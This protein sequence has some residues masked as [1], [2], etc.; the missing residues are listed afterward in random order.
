MNTFVISAMLLF[1]VAGLCRADAPVMLNTLDAGFNARAKVLGPMLTAFGSDADSFISNPAG[2]AYAPCPELG[3]TYNKLLMDTR[4][5]NT[6]FLYPL[7]RSGLGLSITQFD[8]GMF[9][10]IEA[11]QVTDNVLAKKDESVS[12]S[13]GHEI[14]QN[15]SL[16]VTGKYVRSSL[17]ETYSSQAFAADLGLLWQL[18]GNGIS[19]GAALYN[20]GTPMKYL[21]TDESLP[22]CAE[23]GAGISL[24]DTYRSRC[25]AGGGVKW[26]SGNNDTLCGSLAAEYVYNGLLSLRAGYSPGRSHLNPLML[27]VG[28][29]LWQNRLDCAWTNAGI[30]D[31]YRMSFT[32]SFGRSGLL[33]RGMGFMKKN[34]YKRA[35]DTFEKIP[36]AHPVYEEAQSALHYCESE[37]ASQQLAALPASLSVVSGKYPASI[38]L[39]RHIPTSIY[40]ILPGLNCM[41]CLVSIK[42][43][44][45]ETTEFLVKY[46][47]DFQKEECILRLELNP[48]DEK[49]AAFYPPVPTFFGA[50]IA[51][52]DVHAVHISIYAAGSSGKISKIIDDFSEPVIFHPN[53]QFF[54]WIKNAAGEKIQLIDTLAAWVVPNDP[55]LAGV[56]SKASDRGDAASPKIK[57]VGGQDTRIFLQAAEQIDNDYLKQIEM[58]YTTLIKDYHVNYLNQPILDIRGG[59][60]ASQ[61][62]KY[63]GQTLVN[64]GNCIELSVLFASILESIGINPIIVLLPRDGHCVV[65]WEIPGHDR[66]MYRLLETNHFGKDFEAVLR[67]PV[68]WI[69][70]YGLEEQ[71]NKGIV[72]DDK[73]IYQDGNIMILDV[74]SVR[75]RIYPSPY[76]VK[77][78]KKPGKVQ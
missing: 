42:N 21:D 40:N 74:A 26:E 8:G 9:D 54:L 18:P 56:V 71:F 19:L 39:M 48:G 33:G 32:F 66:K 49:T 17:I 52:Q 2:L 29:F 41:P 1:S 6:C 7:K 20:L 13:F 14:F 24:C 31:V 16:G 47:F 45:A 70:K 55:A 30:E 44:T 75:K 77:Q 65:G 28:F 72:F 15:L 23:F 11:G 3:I 12:I 64:K 4:I 73:G 43:N 22:L 10:I 36:A 25:V 58:I 5:A 51:T 35:A 76:A 59:I 27:G 63:P 61:R 68:V 67:E 46:R 78:A 38:K 34:M 60:F 69:Q 57:L 37:I 50:N 53:D 62:I